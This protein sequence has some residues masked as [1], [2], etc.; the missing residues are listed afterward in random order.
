L[1]EGIRWAVDGL[2]QLAERT[3]GKGVHLVYENHAKPGA[4]QHTDFSQPPAVFL[5]ILS[6]VDCPELGVNFDAGNATTFADD[7]L[8]LLERVLPRLTSVH[9]SDTSARGQ[10]K[11]T[12]LGTGLVPYHKIFQRLKKASWDGWIC[13][14]EAS[15]RGREGVILAADFI[16][17]AWAK[18]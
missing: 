18:A 7:P 4:W 3:K 6:R 5:E 11:H 14:E 13:M 15:Y 17:E 2:R 16:R 12:L 10:L 9:A 1:D 8:E